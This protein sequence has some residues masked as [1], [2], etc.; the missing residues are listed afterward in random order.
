MI[1][2]VNN[3][4]NNKLVKM[5]SL[6]GRKYTKGAKIGS[7]T[8]GNVFSVTRDDG[9]IFALKIFFKDTLDI[10]LCV[11]REISILKIFQNSHPSI[12]NME[13]IVMLSNGNVGVIMKKYKQDL[14]MA[15]LN[16]VIKK[17]DKRKIVKKLLEGVV[18]LHDNGVIHRDIK[19]DNI[20]LD[21]NMC[22]VLAD[23]SLSKVFSGMCME[24]THT[25][26]IATVTYRAPEVVAKQKYGFPVDSWSLGIVFYELFTGVPISETK[27]NKT[28]FFIRKQL[29]KMK[30]T[31]LG[32]TVRGLLDSNPLTRW[33]PRDALFSDM[34]FCSP[35]TRRIWIGSDIGFVSE[36]VSE[37]CKYFH[38]EKRVTEWAAETYVQKTG[39]SAHSAVILAHKM[40]ETEP[41]NIDDDCYS[42]DEL[43]I[44]QDMSFNLYI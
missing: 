12:I 19:P 15:I 10:D 6:K 35:E 38:I 36:D 23:F 27:D 44:L 9:S 3:L 22:P 7:G 34:F 43:C 5:K 37:T 1:H 21:Y 26:E 42:I 16:G 25:S 2:E 40:F 4:E 33:T 30:D 11:L 28:L 39:C 20:L 17:Q 41:M 8:F 18:F 14:G 24:G 13:D 29:T 31:P 32:K